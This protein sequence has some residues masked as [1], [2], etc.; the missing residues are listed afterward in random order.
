DNN[1]PADLR[2]Y[3]EAQA[4]A[5]G[6]ELICSDYYLSPNQARNL[7]LRRVSS[8]YVVFVDNDIIFSPG[9]L[10]PLVDC[11]EETGAT[12]VGS[13]VC[14]HQPLHEI[15]H[16]AGGEYMP[17][18]ELKHFL[19]EQAQGQ[20][21]KLCI[22]EKI[23]KQGQR[24]KY[25]GYQLQRQSTGFVEFHCLL[26][27]MDFFEQVGLLDEGL[28]CTKEFLD[29]SMTVAKQGGAVYL[30][31]ASVV[32]FMTHFPAPPLQQSDIPYY[33][34][35]WS[36]AWER[37]SLHH[38]RDKWGLLEDGY[39]KNRY[40][41]LGWRR[42]IEIIKPLAARFAFLGKGATIWLER[43]LFG[44]EKP[45]NYFLTTRYAWKQLQRQQKQVKNHSHPHPSPETTTVT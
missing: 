14:Q 44:L 29:L 35:R 16:C 45:L 6:F 8:K 19:S 25:L 3:L 39:F 41:R 26:V 38:F 22:K 17:A 43:I 23:Y 37:A 34:L 33:M 27:C 30:E 40:K 15:I 31:P 21:N 13:L 12:V 18:K 11:A 4:Q 9:W 20:Q 42:R 5:K 32:T 2:Q 24:I 36:N 10:K 1:A 28:C 7:G